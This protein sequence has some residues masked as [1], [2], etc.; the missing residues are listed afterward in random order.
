MASGLGSLIVSGCVTA[1]DAEA[2]AMPVCPIETRSWQAW[3]NAMPGPDM[4]PTLIVKGEALLP[5]KASATLTA[6]P[7]DRMMPPGQRVTLSVEPS[8]RAAGW[9]EIRLDIAP[10]LPDYASVIVGC[11]GNEIVRITPIEAIQ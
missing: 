3:I 6:G 4:R 2:V 9:Q 8:D 10:A 7:T 1:P 5:E 11:G